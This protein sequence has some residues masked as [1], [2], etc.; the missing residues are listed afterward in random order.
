VD[1]WNVPESGDPT[2]LWADLD[3][4]TAGEALDL[5]AGAYTVGIDV[6]DDE[7]PD[8]TFELP[9]LDAGTVVN[10]FAVADS[11]ENVFLI[12]ELPSGDTAR[13]DPN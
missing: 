9:E 3:F 8:L 4:G 2:P 6:D 5:D 7:T 11:D 12:A 1:I 10:V 13:I